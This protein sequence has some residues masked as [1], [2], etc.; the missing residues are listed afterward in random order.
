[1]IKIIANFSIIS[2]SFLFKTTIKIYID[3]LKLFEYRIIF[4]K[5][6]KLFRAMKCDENNLP[7]LGQSA[8]KLGVRPNKDIPIDAQ[9]YVHPQT[10]GMSVTVD[11]VM[12]LPPHRRPPDFNG[13]GKDPVF[14]INKEQLP[15]TL[16]ARQQ[17]SPHHYLI[18]PSDTCIFAQ[19]EAHLF[20]TRP[21]WVRL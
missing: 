10:G 7:L 9:G 17:G 2:V 16:T 15:R 8:S 13:T 1:M 21:N 18:E 5:M 4:P 3:N 14:S 11:D 12:C 19:Y 6:S 20:S